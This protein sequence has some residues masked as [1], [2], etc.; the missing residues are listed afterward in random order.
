VGGIDGRGDESGTLGFFRIQT[1]FNSKV[2]SNF[3]LSAQLLTC[4]IF[5]LGL[6]EV[7]PTQFDIVCMPAA[8]VLPKVRRHRELLNFKCLSQLYF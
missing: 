6:K 2:L 3:G 7:L 1:S 4:F 5:V 8:A